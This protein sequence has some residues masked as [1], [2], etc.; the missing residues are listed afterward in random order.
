M[1]IQDLLRR[2]AII[3][4]LLLLGI[5]AVRA[6]TG[7]G[8]TQG[9]GNEFDFSDIPVDEETPPYIGVGG[10]Y[11][12][13]YSLLNFDELNKIAEPLGISGFTGGL[14]MNGGGGFTAIGFIPNL[15]LGV[16]GFSG[17][18]QKSTTVQVQDES[19]TRTI[20]LSDGLTLAHIDYAIPLLRAFTVL[21]GVMLGA[22]THTFEI[23]Q[24]RAGGEEFSNLSLPAHFSGDSLG[25]LDQ[26]VRISRSYFAV[27]PTLNLEYA[28]TQFFM[29]RGGVSYALSLVP[30]NWTDGGGTEIKNVP[31]LNTNGLT[32][33]LGLFVGLFQ[34]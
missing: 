22:G 1:T 8:G 26:D 9:G 3:V 2:A 20:R 32:L 15:R 19:V 13:T 34:Q 7:G 6:Q 5:G 14:W 24:T 18:R 30:S 29:L 11:I 33:Q 12:G 21:P 31:E 25:R 28:F 17:S 16:Y 4:A 23:A 10:G 27:T